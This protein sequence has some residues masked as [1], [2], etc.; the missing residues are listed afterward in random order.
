MKTQRSQRGIS[1]LEM[2]IALAVSS[3]V[4]ASLVGVVFGAFALTRA[5]GQRIY[6]SNAATLLPDQLQEDSHRLSICSAG[7]GPSPELDL[8]EAGTSTAVVRYGT[9]A[10]CLI[11]GA[12]DVTRTYLPSGGTTVLARSMLARPQFTVSCRAAAGVSSGQVLVTELRFPPGEGGSPTS[13]SESLVV[14][15]RTPAG[16]C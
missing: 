4:L 8:C 16:G 3:L 11:A 15:F 13:A 12:C 14:F 5:W 2:V 7:A 10:G 9:N 1:V 6:E